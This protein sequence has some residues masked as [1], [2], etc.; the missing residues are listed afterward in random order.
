MGLNGYVFRFT[1]RAFW[2]TLAAVSIPAVIGFA[3]W[4]IEKSINRLAP[5]EVF[6]GSPIPPAA[7]VHVCAYSGLFLCLLSVWAREY[8]SGGSASRDHGPTRD[9]TALCH[10]LELLVILTVQVLQYRA[11]A[12]VYYHMQYHYRPG[13]ISGYV[14]NLIAS[15]AQRRR[16][17]HT[18]CA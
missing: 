14:A 12:D 10:S 7:V 18:I 13:T 3:W 4:C 6:P 2:W 8:T 9:G 15:H 5:Y 17:G 16:G 11:K 1:E